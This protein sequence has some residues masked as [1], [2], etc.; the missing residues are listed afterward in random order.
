MRISR[1]DRPE[2]YLQC[3]VVNYFKFQGRRDLMLFA[4]PNGDLR[5]MNVGLRLK[6]EG[7]RRGVPDL[8]LLLDDGKTGWLELKAKGGSLTDEQI[9]FRN[10]AEQHGHRWACA[11]S[12]DEAA[13]IFSSWGALRADAR[14]PE[15]A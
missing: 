12:L 9:G 15:A 6:A 1:R 11:R 10:V 7:V 14:M 4:I 3:A 5:R 13:R 8:C 2:H